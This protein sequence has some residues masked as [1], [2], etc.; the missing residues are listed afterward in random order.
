MSSGDPISNDGVGATLWLPRKASTPA[1]VV[2]PKMADHT[3]APTVAIARHELQENWQGGQVT[4]RLVSEGSDNDG[5]H[6]KYKA[7]DHSAVV[8]ARRPLGLLYGTYALLRWL[9]RRMLN[10]W[11]NPD[12]SVE[13]GYAGKSIWKWEQITK[14]SMTDSLRHR[15]TIYARANASVGI[16]AVVVNNV[17]ASPKMVTRPYLEKLKVIADLLRPYGIQVWLSINFGSPLALHETSSR[18]CRA[19]VVAAQGTGDLQT[20]TGLRR[21]PR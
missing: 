8:S 6:I 7:A 12:G 11:D 2:C 14:S 3:A 4:L 13:R 17:N 5:Y 9:Q 21:F 18:R 19:A 20:D 16:N 15:L 10:H 1:H